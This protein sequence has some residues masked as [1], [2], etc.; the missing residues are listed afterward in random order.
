M[1]DLLMDY[2]DVV[3]DIAVEPEQ[4]RRFRWPLIV[5]GVIAIAVLTGGGFLAAPGLRDGRLISGAATANP[6]AV[7]EAAAD[8]KAQALADQK[9]RDDALLRTLERQ[10][11]SGM[12]EYFNDPANDMGLPITV[13]DLSLIKVA[14]NKYEG[15][16]TMK[17]GSYSA[18]QVLIHVTADDRN[19]M[20]QTD[21]G[22]LVPLFR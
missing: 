10:V 6:T 3:A 11:R 1:N 13:I 12:Q 18:R 2:D 14:D 15:T 5:A 16:A 7:V 20:W 17:A 4:R 8:R 22:A 9:V 21:P 19:I